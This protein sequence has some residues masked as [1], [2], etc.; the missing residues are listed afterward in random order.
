MNIFEDLNKELDKFLEGE[1]VSFT[2]FKKQKYADRRKERSA[3][4]SAEIDKMMNEVPPELKG[5]REEL[6]KEEPKEQGKELPAK[7]YK[8]SP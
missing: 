6:Y 2:D 7:N 8:K 1:V 5:D 4:V 3:S